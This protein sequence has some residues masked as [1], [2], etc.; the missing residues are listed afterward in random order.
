M[1][2][3]SISDNKLKSKIT[4]LDDNIV[5]NDRLLELHGEDDKEHKI[6]IR[7]LVYLTISLVLT[8]IILLIFYYYF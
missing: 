1:G 3:R 7:Y 4:K 8:I 2:E 6:Y 5:K